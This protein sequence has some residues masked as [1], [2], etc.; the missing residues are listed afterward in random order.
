MTGQEQKGWIRRLI[1]WIAPH[2]R[3]AI[4]TFSVAI[5]GTAIAAFAPLVQKIIVDDVLTDPSRPL[6]PWLLLLVVFGVTRF[7]L[8]FVRRFRGGRIALA[9][10]HD[11]RTAI[12]RQLQRLDFAS[13]DEMQTG[14]LVSRAGSD[15][16]LIQGLLQFLPIVIGNVLMFLIS[17]VIM[18]VLSPLLALVMLLVT[19]ALLWTALRLRT[20][21]FP[22]SWDAQQIA[23]EVATVVEESVTGVR[24]VKGFGQ[25]Q[26]QLDQL[27][28]RSRGLF[29]SRLRLVRIQARLQS[30]MQ[31]I[32]ALGMVAVLAV[33]GWLALRGEISLGVFLAFSSY[34]LALVAPVRMFAGMLTIAQLARAGAE[35]IFE[36]LDS[37]PLV[38]ERPDAAIL[39][40]TR[41]EI[42]FDAVTFGYLRTEPVL[43]DFSLT[44]EP[45]ETVAL[46]GTSGSGKSTV[47][48]LLPRFYD[49]HAGSVRIDDV[50]VR[51]VTLSSLREQIGVV[52][53]DSFLFSDTIRNNIAF[54][55]P[56][57][58]DADVEAAARAVEAHEFV[59]GLPDGYE[60]VVGEQGLTLSG[61]Q[62]QR[63]ALARALLSDPRILLL[64]DATSSVDARVEAEIHQT[65]RRLL[66]GRTTVL[67]AHRRSTLEL[68]DRIVVVDQGRVVDEGTHTEL[69]ARC[70]VYRNLLAGPGDDVEGLDLEAAANAQVAADLA[71]AAP[72][73]DGVTPSAWPDRAEAAPIGIAPGA[74]PA[75][76]IGRMGGPM[77]GGMGPALAPTPE[78]LEKVAA[79]PPAADEP[80]V[81][82]AAQTKLET[83]FRFTHFLRPFR[84][85]LAAGLLLVTLDGLAT[86]AGPWLIRYG[87]NEGVAK[88]AE[89]ALWAASMAFLL[90]TLADWWVM[91]AQTRVM[92]RTSER[93]LFAL[94]VKLFA[95]LQRLG[96][97][98]FEREMA[99]RI[100]TRMTTDVDSLSQFLQTG[101]VTA[102]VN[103]ITLVGVA[104]ALV[105]MNWQLALAT[106]LVLPPL[107]AATVWFQRNSSR[108]YDSARQHIAT[109]N[110]NLQEGLSGVRVSQAYV[111]EGTNQ[112]EFE[113]VARGYLNARLGAQ[114][115]VAMYFP[116]VEMLS[117]LAAALVLG[118]GSVMLTD[119]TLQTGTLIAFLLY[120][121]LFFSPIQQLSQTFDSYQ[122]ARVS[123]DRVD[124]L[125]LRESSVPPATDPIVPD[126]IVGE[127]VFHD[128]VFRYPQTISDALR[129]VR[130]TI[131]AGQSVAL[132]G[133]TGAGKSTVLKLVARFYD[134]TSGEV[135]VDG[136]P[137]GRYDPV[138]YHGHLGIVPQE[139]Y[140]FSGTIRDNI[141]FGRADATD[142]E[143]EAAARA[144]SAHDFI[145]ALPHGYLTHVSER[146]RSLSSGQRQLIAL[147]RAHLV[148]PAILLLDEAT[149]NLDLATEARVTAAMR[150]AARGRTT[151]LIAHRLQTARLADRILVVDDGRVVEDGSHA[152]LLAQGG[153]YARLWE[154]STDSAPGAVVTTGGGLH[155][156]A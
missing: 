102:L 151:I 96:I 81:D 103:G 36:L 93:M 19:P 113:T 133:E 152:S 44:V 146:G 10:Q 15:I 137:V 148:D 94:R 42:T 31:T 61:G 43:R 112:E 52:F 37:T 84:W 105:L 114:K 7:G 123:L 70:L 21:V 149:S 141:A 28:H 41:G 59:I 56:D 13:H 89:G 127:V 106:S 1:T 68:A 55:R 66:V 40:P 62:R 79:L 153:R 18:V 90:I 86:L 34:M 95:H 109:V 12:F 23:G 138:S 48:L 92:G 91:W 11:L 145:A 24:I 121:D 64:D 132:V 100:M 98:Y 4:A 30:L 20:A 35:R 110:A 53:E 51:D 99:G 22:A 82:I 73:G 147:A 45:G 130:F 156:G 88:D 14:Q 155:P 17:L 122:Q 142:A 120:L 85:P 129:G 69:I 77:G 83:P 72:N 49:V 65:L 6:W 67:I 143:V 124:E 136:V 9:V 134:P 131:P 63:I 5:A 54:A 38:Q 101:L 154:A 118:V 78:L 8:A 140:L 74:A 16:M 47:G 97:D 116:F 29:A 33:G 2:K 119:H 75:A 26:R 144:V 27:T 46:V 104:V 87:I 39:T 76:A 139:A 80:D 117:E 135:L 57:A 126:E 50:D 108:A 115:L 107:I 3:D 150:I 32:P 25:E 125:L 60:T 71:A 128:V 58:S 111:R